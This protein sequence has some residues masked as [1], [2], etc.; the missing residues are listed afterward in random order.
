MPRLR[1]R[2]QGARGRQRRHLRG[3]PAAPAAAAEPIFFC[4]LPSARRAAVG[5]APRATLACRQ[6]VAGAA[7][8]VAARRVRSRELTMPAVCSAV[9]RRRAGRGGGRRRRPA[10]IPLD[11]RP[12]PPSGPASHRFRCGRRRRRRP[13]LRLAFGRGRDLRRRWACGGR[14]W[15]EAGKGGGHPLQVARLCMVLRL[16]T[17]GGGVWV[18]RDLSPTGCPERACGGWS[19]KHPSR[20]GRSVGGRRSADAGRA[21]A[22]GARGRFARAV[23]PCSGPFPYWERGQV[24]FT[25]RTVLSRPPSVWIPSPPALPFSS[26]WAPPPGSGQSLRPPTLGGMPRALTAPRAPPRQ[27]PPRPGRA[28]ASPRPP[29]CPS[30]APA[31]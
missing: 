25:P 27:P 29:G 16:A 10:S 13:G 17:G 22:G 18:G 20:G 9:E 5:R 24:P 6:S 21:A 7:L 26:L 28:P 4:V 15:V 31:S 23:G 14:R 11:P 30:P 2:T 3:V 12:R 8:T 1:R 19:A